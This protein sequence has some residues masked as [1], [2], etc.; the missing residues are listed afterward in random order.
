MAYVKAGS[1]SLFS[2]ESFLAYSKQRD[3]ITNGRL[4][5]EDVTFF[6]AMLSEEADLTKT[7]E[8][9]EVFEFIRRYE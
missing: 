4:R 7:P 9:M 2:E 3:V 1:E 8:G 6:D 5:G